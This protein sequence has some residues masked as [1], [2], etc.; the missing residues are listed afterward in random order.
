MRAAVYVSMESYSLA[1]SVKSNLSIFNFNPNLPGFRWK[2]ITNG[3][4]VGGIFADGVNG[5]GRG[6]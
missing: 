3:K 5:C 2:I 1:F 6:F 4:K